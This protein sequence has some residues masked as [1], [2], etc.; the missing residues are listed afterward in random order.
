MKQRCK[1]NLLGILKPKIWLLQEN[2]RIKVLKSHRLLSKP[3]NSV[4][5]DR[6]EVK[7]NKEMVKTLMAE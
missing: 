7:R 2:E 6:L 5:K 3:R 1:N 4:K